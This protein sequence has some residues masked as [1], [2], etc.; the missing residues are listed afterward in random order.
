[1]ATTQYPSTCLSGR[2][3]DGRISDVTLHFSGCLPIA[4][5]KRFFQSLSGE[6]QQRIVRRHR[7]VDALRE[8]LETV[9]QDSN[10]AAS[11]RAFK[12]ALSQWRAARGRPSHYVGSSSQ[13][14]SS[15][16]QYHWIDSDVDGDIKA[17]VIYFKDGKPHNAPGIPRSFPHQ[18]VTVRELLADDA[19]A[20]PLMQPCEPGTVRYFHLPANNMLW[21]EEAV[22]RYYHEKRPD[23]D[24]F[25]IN[26]KMRRERTRTERLLG[27]EY[28]Q[29]QSN[30]G[31]HSEVHAR[32][33]R[34]FSD[35]ISIGMSTLHADEATAYWW[36]RVG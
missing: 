26:C 34:P 31:P 3:H 18:K 13:T 25:V 6:S 9:A 24:D 7:K 15:L 2:P 28:W 30:Y 23:A 21:V 4:K 1:M 32:H 29:G 27:A 33:M 14:P 10:A 12:T 11:L 8:K 22:A 36:R 35:G 20:N 5:R 17:P 16:G 19:A